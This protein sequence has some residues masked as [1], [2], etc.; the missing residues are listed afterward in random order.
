M[1][2]S[3]YR[4]WNDNSEDV[5]R[6]HWACW[7]HWRYKSLAKLAPVVVLGL[8]V[9]VLSILLSKASKERGELLDHQDLLKANASKQATTLEV[10]QKKVGSCRTS[11][12]EAQAQL[13]TTQAELGVA[14][15]TL[16]EQGNA[17]SELRERVTKDVAQACRDHEDIRSELLRA[18]ESAKLGN[19]TCEP[20]PTSWM[21]FEGSCYLFSDTQVKWEAAQKSCVDAGAHLVIVG[22]LE[23]QTFLTANTRGFGYWLGLKA[24]RHQGKIQS[25]EWVDG[26]QLNFSHW[27]VG[28]PNDSRG[29]ENCIMML[30]TGL[31]NDAPCDNENDNWICE[32]RRKC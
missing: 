27:N 25:Y 22:G 24:V 7:E 11:C 15:K 30:R 14:Q 21:P 29:V 28:E 5:P 12:S 9:L 32:K 6:G 13:Q 3:G 4:K 19:H 8:W 1:D 16:L 23:E 31:W 10:L 26:V 20:C 2:N 17:L 18:L